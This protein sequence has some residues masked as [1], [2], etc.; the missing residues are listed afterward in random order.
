MKFP[1]Q[2]PNRDARPDLLFLPPVRPLLALYARRALLGATLV[3]PRC[4]CGCCEW[5]G[6]C[7]RMFFVRLL[8]ILGPACGQISSQGSLSTATLR[9]AE[10]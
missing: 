9:L 1:A 10:Q 3:E 5:E 8:L 2:K 4:L 7:R 6:A